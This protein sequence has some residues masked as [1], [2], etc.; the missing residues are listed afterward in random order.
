MTMAGI[1][2]RVGWDRSAILHHPRICQGEA[3]KWLTA[4]R[5]PDPARS[6]SNPRPRAAFA[7][8]TLVLNRTV[9]M[10]KPGKPPLV[11]R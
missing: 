2:R 3:K 8:L 5:R 1:R 11:P 4:H 9:V 6:T 10:V 7:A